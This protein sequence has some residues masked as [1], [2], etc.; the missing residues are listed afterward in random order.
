MV[1]GIFSHVS[2]ASPDDDRRA[3]AVYLRGL[4]RAAAAGLRP[5]LR[6]LAASA[7]ALSIP[8]AR[9]DLVRLGIVDLR[10]LP[11]RRVGGASWDSGR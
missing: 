9:F 11:V 7:A 10:S 4:D 2:N 6:H 5:E 1:R 8:D 3:L